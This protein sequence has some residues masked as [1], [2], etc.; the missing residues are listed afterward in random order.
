MG[1]LP[2]ILSF[3]VVF[4]VVFTA[5]HGR[6]TTTSSPTH[7]TESSLSVVDRINLLDPE[8]N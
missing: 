4:G 1:R 3:L 5:V 7:P 8:G 2:I 6:T